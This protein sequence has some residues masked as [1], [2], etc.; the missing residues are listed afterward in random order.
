MSLIKTMLGH[1]RVLLVSGTEIEPYRREV[2]VRSL[3]ATKGRDHSLSRHQKSNEFGSTGGSE[4][5]VGK[6]KEGNKKISLPDWESN[7]GLPRLFPVGIDKR[8]S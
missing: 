7:P 6:Q 2:E 3:L 4:E 1:G 8:K 5:V